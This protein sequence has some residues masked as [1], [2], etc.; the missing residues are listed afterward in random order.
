MLPLCD[1]NVLG[2][3]S[4]PRPNPGVLE[5]A[6]AT[7]ELAVSSVTVEE[8]IFGLTWKPRPKTSAW[9]EGFLA[10]HCKVLPVTERIARVAGGFRGR[11]QARG[12]TRTQADMLIAATASA[13]G[14]TLVT[15]N[16]PDFE[17]CGIDLVDPFT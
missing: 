11:F 7:P 14:L 15:R 4:R 10:D 5:W 9:F 2:E 1:T 3:L 17:G 16:L 6:R 13:H 8:V 12:E